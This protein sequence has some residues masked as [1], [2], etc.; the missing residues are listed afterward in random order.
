M[1]H[2]QVLQFPPDLYHYITG[3]LKKQV[4]LVLNKID[5]CPAPLI[6]AWKHYMVSQFPDLHTVCFTSQRGP[7]NTGEQQQQKKKK[8][9][10]QLT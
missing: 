10:F 4:I 1:L 2:L 8:T 9:M 6:I 5:L 7:T 3:D